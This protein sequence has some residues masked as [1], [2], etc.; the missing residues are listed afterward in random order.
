MSEIK[1]GCMVIGVAQ[2]NC[3]YLKREGGDEAIVCDPADRGDFIYE[4]LK[5]KG[6]RVAGILL[7]HGHFDHILG[8]AKLC[9]MCEAEG[10]ALKIYAGAAEKEICEDAEK[11]VSEMLGRPCTVV[12]DEYLQDGEERTLAGLTFQVIATP[13]HTIGSTCYYFPSEKVLL[14]G[15]T[16]FRESVGRDDLPTGNGRA[17]VHSIRERLFTLP[18]ETIIY[19]GHGETSEIGHE[20]QYNPF[21]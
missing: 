6:L 4:Q 8:V 19:P 17:L 9:E 14:S 13:G 1:I 3:Y 15:D 10:T 16:L 20:K 18:D 12:A 11:N 21:V 2:T 5:A 7:T